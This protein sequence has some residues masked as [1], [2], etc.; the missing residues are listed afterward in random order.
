MIKLFWLILV[1]TSQGPTALH[2]P[3]TTTFK[4]KKACSEWG[5]K[6]LPRMKD[7]ARG[8]LKADWSDDI[9]VI[10]RCEADGTP[11]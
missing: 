2:V 7:Y 4:D 6:Q 3:E 11:A 10:F 9:P 8:M 5:M 1:V